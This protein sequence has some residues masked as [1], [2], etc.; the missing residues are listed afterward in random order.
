MSPPPTSIDGTDITGATIDGQEVQEITVDGQT[1]FTAG[2]LIIDDFED[3]DADPAGIYGSNEDIEDYYPNKNG[4]SYHTRTTTN[5]LQ[6]S[7]AVEY[8][9]GSAVTETN[10]SLP[11]DGLNTYPSDGDLVGFLIRSGSSTAY[12]LG[13]MVQDSTTPGAYFFEHNVKNGLIRINKA[14]DLSLSNITNDGTELSL[15]DVSLN[16]DWYWAEVQLPS[17]SDDTITF[18]IYNVDSNL[19]K[20]SFVASTSSNDSSFLGSSGVAFSDFTGNGGGETFADW[21]RIL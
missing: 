18:E 4:D 3:A 16:T 6:G 21:I 12:G 1:V 2:P 9:S 5:V 19:N 13:L 10:W 15:T 17:S 20:G 14:N 8:V 7:Q 11:G